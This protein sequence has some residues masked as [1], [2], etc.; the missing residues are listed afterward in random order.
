MKC[1]VERDLDIY[2]DE[3]DCIERWEESTRSSYLDLD[4][5]I[6]L[7]RL[8]E[9]YKRPLAIF[10]EQV[11]DQSIYRGLPFC[12]LP[13]CEENFLSLKTEVDLGEF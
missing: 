12:E 10:L 5:V 6:K 1:V 13:F 8:D 11:I 9:K 7:L 2:L 3:L 4:D